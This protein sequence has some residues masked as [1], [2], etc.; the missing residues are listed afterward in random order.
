MPQSISFTS[1]GFSLESVTLS[2]PNQVAV[3]FTFDPLQASPSGTHDGLNPANYSITGPGVAIISG[4]ILGPD[5]QTLL[6]QL[7]A[8]L[9]SGIWTLTASTNIQTASAVSLAA[10]R[11]L[12]FTVNFVSPAPPVNGGATNDDAEQFLRKNLS[13]ALKGPAWDALVA[14]IATGDQDNWDNAKLAFDQLFVI[15]AS[16]KYLDRKLGDNGVRRPPGIGLSDALF[17]QLGIS[18]NAN[19]LTQESFLEVLEIFYG[20]DAVRAFVDAIDETYPLNN[21]DDLRV[22]IDEKDAISITFTTPEFTLINQATALEVAASITR[23]IRITG[24]LGFAVALQDPQTGHN[25]IRIYSG[26][27]G[28]RSS[29]RVTGGKA[30][31]A[32]QFPTLIPIPAVVSPSTFSWNVTNPSP[33]VARYTLASGGASFDLTQ[34]RIGDYANIFGTSF[35]PANRGSFPIINVFVAYVSSVL[36]QY[37]DID[38]F[39]VAPQSGAVQSTLKD[40]L[41]FRPTR[42]TIQ[43]NGNRTV[44]VDQS[45]SGSVDVVIPATSLAVQRTALTAAYGQVSPS[46]TNPNGSGGVWPISRNAQGVVTVQAT[47]HGLSAGQQI[48]VDDVYP[49]DTVPATTPGVPSTT[50]NPGTS[51]HSVMT[52]VSSVRAPDVENPTYHGAVLLPNSNDVLVVGGNIRDLAGPQNSQSTAERFRNLGAVTNVNGSITYSYNWITTASMSAARERFGTVA[53]TV[54]NNLG[55]ALVVGGLQVTSGPTYAWTSATEIYNEVSNVWTAG[56]ALTSARSSL[57]ANVLVSGQVVITGGAVSLNSAAVNTVDLMDS[58]QAATSVGT[59]MAFARAEHQALS[60]VSPQGTSKIIVIGGRSLALPAIYDNGGGGTPV[61]AEWAFDETAGTTAA[62]LTGNYPLTSSGPVPFPQGKIN[63]A[64]DFTT[65]GSMSGAGDAAAVTA[66]LGDWTIEAW[67]ANVDLGTPGQDQIILSYENTGGSGGSDNILAQVTVNTDGSGNWIVGIN[68]QNGTNSPASGTTYGPVSQNGVMWHHVAFSKKQDPPLSGLFT[69]T[70]YFDG[71]QIA[72]DVPG[73][74]NASGGSISQWNIGQGVQVVNQFA[75]QIDDVRVSSRC[76]S[77]TEIYETWLRGRGDLLFAG[78]G[79]LLASTEVYSSGSWTSGGRMSWARSG[80][81][82][83]L[84]PDGRILVTG[85]FAYLDVSP[86]SMS[87]NRS[88]VGTPPPT[89]VA[90]VWDPHTQVWYP[91]GSTIFP[92]ANHVAFYVPGINKVVVMGGD[93]DAGGNQAPLVYEFWDPTTNLWNTGP[94]GIPDLTGAGPQEISL[95]VAVPLGDAV[96]GCLITGGEVNGGTPVPELL[97]IPNSN[98]ISNGG[99]NGVQT[100]ASI[101]DANHF[102]YL[103]PGYPFYTVNASTT[104]N[105]TPFK[106]V[107]STIPGPF[108]WDTKGGS[109]I[110]SITT[111]TT[112][113]LFAGQQYTQL[114]VASSA[115]FPDMPGY[116]ILNFGTDDAVFPVPYFGRFSATALSLDFS[117]IFP[118]DVPLG[119]SVTLLIA[120]GIYVPAKPEAVGS[121]YLTDS[122]SGRVAAQQTLSSIQ[123][124]GLNVNVIVRYPGDRGLGGEGLGSH[125]QK[126]SDEVTIWGSNDMDAD[127]AAARGGP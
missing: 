109:G 101:I 114:P 36:T 34:V 98:V 44:V 104:S 2:A 127:E 35:L 15:S 12:T 84:L 111:T 11:I 66:L 55:G 87:N 58:N 1:V 76:R 65:P 21:G 116:L 46:L 68:Y 80:H 32:L 18:V 8:P 24:S 41:F 52:I 72:F 71:T 6:I 103:T 16:G 63:Y 73:Q 39:G 40:V 89:Q 31:N 95:C 49:T 99:M 124:E 75:G 97:F 79:Q 7:T 123:G 10:P 82:A 5:S 13:K 57:A 74:S 88:V 56:P 42:A 61:L 30:Q 45:T 19:K 69:V 37:F 118:F 112:T 33:G 122:N 125:G 47:A 28:L 60:F 67:I 117:F 120:K 29:V 4:I 59:P 9:P 77:P 64:R 119:A 38:N 106:A 102:T 3:R 83:T 90:E 51:D 115:A 107:A 54:G 105:I 96:G 110:T 48:Y 20:N 85:G 93:V 23:Q 126:F 121:F 14:A 70:A 78:N 86:A 62:D 91:A 26:A 108:S 94:T 50:G 27:I 53:L 17:R 113:M 22:L 25:K 92:R 43:A 81:Q 100:V